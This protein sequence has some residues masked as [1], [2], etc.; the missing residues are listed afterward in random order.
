MTAN[1]IRRLALFSLALLLAINLVNFIDRY[2]LAAV[3]S[4]VQNELLPGDPRAN[5]KMG[6]L[7]TAFL[8]SYMALSPLFGF[9]GDRFK[10]WT[11]IGIGV[12]LWSL[13]SGASGLAHTYSLM[14][15]TRVFV[16]VGEAAYA[17]IAPTIISDLFPVEKRGKV[18]SLFYMAIPVGSALG[19]GVGGL[20]GKYATWHWA[21]FAMVIPG[22]LLGLWSLFMKEPPRVVEQITRHK[23]TMQDYIGLLKN[24][25][26]VLNCIGMTALTFAMGGIAYWMP[27]YISD[28]RQ[29]GSIDKVNMI[30]GLIT[31]ITGISAT[32]LGGITADALRK[33]LRGAYFMVSATGLV[34][35]FPFFLLILYVPFPYAWGAIFLAEFCLFFNTGPSNTALANV[36][37]ASVRATAFA[38]NILV[39]HLLGDAF[40]PP[41]I[42][43]IT[44]YFHGN[45]NAGFLAVGTVILVGAAA[46]YAGAFYLDADTAR[47]SELEAV[48]EVP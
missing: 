30:F 43:A 36:T 48:K 10:R 41:I 44:D 34:A 17:P 33:R 3:V 29:Q 20:A 22:I 7:Q 16:G 11:I 35:S 28:Y 5:E 45:M 46:W 13:A 32:L 15:L 1:S 14:L 47:V 8:V 23:A 27:K 25:S 18:M 26:Y 40:S 37:T 9:L 42:G 19:Y 12:V 2:I 24:R 38:L 21:F 31:V 6:Y 39:I 4:T